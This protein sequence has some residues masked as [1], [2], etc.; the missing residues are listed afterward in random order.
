MQLVNLRSASVQ[1][2]LINSIIIS[3]TIMITIM[4]SKG[5]LWQILK[6]VFFTLFGSFVLGKGFPKWRSHESASQGTLVNSDFD[7]VK[8]KQ[9]SGVR[10]RLTFGTLRN[11]SF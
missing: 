3:I 9:S 4:F 11:H 1:V 2:I 8:S 10:D 5:A 7:G 6:V